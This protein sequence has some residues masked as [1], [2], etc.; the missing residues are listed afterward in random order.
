MKIKEKLL[1]VPSLAANSVVNDE[2]FFTVWLGE[3]A[4]LAVSRE[5]YIHFLAGEKGFK[6]P[7]TTFEA[8]YRKLHPDELVI[9]KRV[10]LRGGWPASTPPGFTP[11]MIVNAFRT[12]A[13]VECVWF[14]GK[15]L[16]RAD[17]DSS[18]LET[19]QE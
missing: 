13:V 17:F 4:A 3:A 7:I 11:D 10:R 5:G 18:A 15:T 12:A 14:D 8:A 16:H 19:V 2:E 9:G 1:S 6:V